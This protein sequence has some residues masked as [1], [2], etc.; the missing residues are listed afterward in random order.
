M[1][2]TDCGTSF[3]APL[4]ARRLA[5]LDALIEGD[6]SRETLL[7]LMIHF[8]RTPD[9]YKQRSVRH[10]TRNLIGFGVPTSAERMLQRDDTEI[11]I[12][13]SA[14]IRPGEDNWFTFSWPDA[15]VKDGGKCAG[16]A[17]LTIVAK[18]PIAHEHGDER[19][20]ANIGARLMQSDGEGGYKTQ[21]SPV[22]ALPPTGS[23]H[24]TERELIQ[25]SM[26]WQVVKSFHTGK[27]QGRGSSSEWKL[28]IDYL[29]RADEKLPVDGVEYAAILTISDPKGNAPIFAQMR[30]HL[31]SI[32]LRTGDLRTSIRARART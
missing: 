23:I 29:E 11:T 26:K 21:M 4:V 7:A 17:R 31:N 16:E 6:V 2:V 3:A 18:P 24:P 9:V 32:G 25:E 30:Q 5:D 22:N 28:Q 19:V 20:R 1:L 12:V 14:T 8:A 27:M 13:I 15:L 10:M